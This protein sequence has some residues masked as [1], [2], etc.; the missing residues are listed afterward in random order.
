MQMGAVAYGRRELSPICCG[1][2]ALVDGA[3]AKQLVHSELV[4]GL[5]PVWT[6]A[7]C[8]RNVVKEL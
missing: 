6:D 5:H 7:Q 8:V 1:V 4:S 2:P 3:L